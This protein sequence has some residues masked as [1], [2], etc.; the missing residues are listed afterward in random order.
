MKMKLCIHVYDISVY[1]CYVTVDILTKLKQKCFFLFFSLWMYDVNS[2][3]SVYRTFAEFAEA[4]NSW[5][6]LD[7]CLWLDPPSFN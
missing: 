2:Q 5:L 3:V 4:L 1:F 7:D 6:K